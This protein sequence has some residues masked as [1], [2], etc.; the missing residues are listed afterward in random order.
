MRQI[1][2]GFMRRMLRA[3]W[4]CV[5]LFLVMGASGNPGRVGAP[6]A[7]L[8]ATAPSRAAIEAMIGAQLV[9]PSN[10]SDLSL[11]KRENVD[12]LL[13]PVLLVQEAVSDGIVLTYPQE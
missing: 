4:L 8:H 12:F 13:T 2:K 6:D 7:P 9:P 1:G 3:M 10:M 11:A 5:F